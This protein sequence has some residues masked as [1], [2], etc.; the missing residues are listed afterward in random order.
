[1]IITLQEAKDV[2]RLSTDD[3]NDIITAMILTIPSYI[4]T[5]TGS[6]SVVGSYTALEKQVAKFILMQWYDPASENNE[7]ISKVINTLLTAITVNVN[8]NNK[9]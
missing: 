8:K 5:A 7:R 3:N 1:M 2:L 9:N 6:K 4:E